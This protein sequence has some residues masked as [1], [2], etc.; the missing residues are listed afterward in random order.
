MQAVVFPYWAVVARRYRDTG[1]IGSECR[2]RTAII[3]TQKNCSCRH[4]VHK[5]CFEAHISKLRIYEAEAGV[6][7]RVWHNR[8]LG[9]GLNPVKSGQ[10]SFSSSSLNKASRSRGNNSL[11]SLECSQEVKARQGPMSEC[12]LKR[13]LK[14]KRS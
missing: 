10:Y 6:P 2:N 5:T 12:R 14:T 8:R 3:W 4:K 7:S 11:R 13:K 1:S 9:F